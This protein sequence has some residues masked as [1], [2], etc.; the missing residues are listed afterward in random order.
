MGEIKRLNIGIDIWTLV[1]VK[2]LNGHILYFI[3][4]YH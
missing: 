1:R 4:F 3:I 2:I